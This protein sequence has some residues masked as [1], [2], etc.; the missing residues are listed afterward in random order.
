MLGLKAPQNMLG[1]VAKL[2]SLAG[3]GTSEFKIT[4][5]VPQPIAQEEPPDFAKLQA[6]VKE[7]DGGNKRDGFDQCRREARKLSRC[8]LPLAKRLSTSEDFVRRFL[9]AIILVRT[10]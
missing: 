10:T 3:D 1:I 5:G 6:A 2:K 7:I 9:P 8:G 4:F